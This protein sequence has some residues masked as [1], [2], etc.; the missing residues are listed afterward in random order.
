[1]KLEIDLFM[2]EKN[3]VEIF[4]SISVNLLTVLGRGTFFKYDNPTDT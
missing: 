3:C 4:M 2:S 1:M